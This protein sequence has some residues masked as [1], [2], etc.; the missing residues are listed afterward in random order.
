MNVTRQLRGIVGTMGTWAAA[1]AIVGVVGLLPL[2]ALGALPPFELKAFLRF[3]INSALR[4]GL[5][6]AGMGLAFS[7]AVVL[8]ARRRTLVALPLRRFA[9]WGFVAGAI[10]PMG[11]ATIYVLTGHSSIAINLRTGLIFAGICGTVG[12]ALAAVSLRAARVGSDDRTV[13]HL[14]R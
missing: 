6:G 2:S 4:W 12:G 9:A 8:G 1:F 13:R 11:L 5:G 14:E 7:V 10:V 3:A